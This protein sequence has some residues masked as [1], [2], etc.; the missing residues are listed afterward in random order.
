MRVR[1][2]IVYVCEDEHMF[3]D[4]CVDVPAYYDA[5]GLLVCICVCMPR[6]MP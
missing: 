3:V 6:R 4:M 2:Y 1:V 5:P